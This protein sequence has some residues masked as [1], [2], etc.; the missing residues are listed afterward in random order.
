[1]I[2]YLSGKIIRKLPKGLIIETNNVGYLVF[3]ATPLLDQS[4]TGEKID[5]FIHTKVREDDI[6]LFGFES[7]DNLEFFQL[8]LSVNGVGPK[9]ALEII[10]APIDK[11]KAAILSGDIAYLSKTPGIG[12]KTAERMIVELK[13][14][15]TWKGTLEIREHHSI[16]NQTEDEIT[17]ALLNLGYQKNE[18]NRI[19]QKLPQEIK[20]TEEAITYFLKN[21]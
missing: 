2:A 1:M 15:I 18:I 3:V 4:K 20:T 13:S 9:T 6:S 8:L 19:I 16:L 17:E 11:T 7:F 21:V 14:K 10:S 5:L 12:K